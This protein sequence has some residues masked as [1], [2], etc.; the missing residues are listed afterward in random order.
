[1]IYRDKMEKNCDILAIF[2]W[3]KFGSC[4]HIEA[5][6]NPKFCQYL[7]KVWSQFCAWKPSLL[8]INMNSEDLEQSHGEISL[9][10]SPR[11]P[12]C[13]S[14][15]AYNWSWW[16]V[17]TVLFYLFSLYSYLFCQENSWSKI[18]KPDIFND[19][20]LQV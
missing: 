2:G 5:D 1:M 18:L 14:K 13:F 4:F 19:I 16:R 6:W 11:E 8:C 10:L 7:A 20:L 9:S 3:Q 17:P 15:Y 12:T